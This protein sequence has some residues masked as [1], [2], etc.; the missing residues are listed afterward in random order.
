MRPSGE[1]RAVLLGALCEH[2]PLPTRELCAITQVGLESARRTVDNLRRAGVLEIVGHEKRAHST[3]W[4]ALYDMAPPEPEPEP[5]DPDAVM[6]EAGFV[7]L[8]EV[9]R[10]WR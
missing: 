1:I 4:V 7:L 3:K 8:G 9:L 6:H 5:A 10:G 2:G